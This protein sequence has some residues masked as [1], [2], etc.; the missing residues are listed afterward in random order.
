[1]HGCVTVLV[2]HV[3]VGTLGHQQLHQFSVALR[4]RQLQW[5]LVP[6]VS[7]VDVTASLLKKK[8]MFLN[9]KFKSILNE[10]Y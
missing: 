8:I 3:Y 7:D 5:R 2:L 6:V 10:M 9:Q 1:M 4:H